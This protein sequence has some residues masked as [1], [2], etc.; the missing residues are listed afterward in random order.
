MNEKKVL[1]VTVTYNPVIS[2]LLR[3]IDA[4]LLS[5]TDI[6]IVD[7]GSVNIQ[8]LEA[9]LADCPGQIMLM[10]L[11][12]NL[13]IASAQNHG[14]RRAREE[15]YQY[16]LLMD[17]DSLPAEDMVSELLK[18]IAQL[19]DAVAVGPN[20]IDDNHASRARFIR[21]K[22]LRI[23]RM[24]QEASD[25]IVEV[26][27]LIASGSLIPVPML[28]IA[29]PMDESLFIDYVDT[30][31][32][33]RARS[34]GLRSYGI[35]SAKMHHALGNDHIEILGRK[36]AVHSPQRHYYMVRNAVL[37]YKK[38]YIPM[39][40]KVVDACKLVAKM[41]VLLIGSESRRENAIAI[42]QGLKHGIF[43]RS[44]KCVLK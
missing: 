27:H 17:Q 20:F 42:M 40:W 39:S 9:S 3:Q 11:G 8:E 19:P 13:G 25:N 41:V 5:Q 21:V 23:I 44:G 12:Q 35:F 7:N 15:E 30:E 4:L 18:G 43:N 24:T 36:V 2:D 31:W 6:F 16:I 33:L 10:K 14:I 28:A 32:A 37:L 22:G 1:A 26:D 38:R 29:G 34:K